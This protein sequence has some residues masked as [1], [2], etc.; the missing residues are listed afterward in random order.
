MRVA[1]LMYRRSSGPPRHPISIR[2]CP[3][4][5]GCQRSAGPRRIYQRGWQRVCR[6]HLGARQRAVRRTADTS[7]GGPLD[8]MPDSIQNVGR[9]IG[10]PVTI[11]QR[12]EFAVEMVSP[13]VVFL[14]SNVVSQALI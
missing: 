14:I 2:A 5:T 7:R 9:I 13:V 12:E 4:D 10:E 6:C 8:A 11:Q 3:I 1:L